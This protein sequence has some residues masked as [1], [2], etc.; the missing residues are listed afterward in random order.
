MVDIITPRGTFSIIINSRLT[1]PAD[2]GE[3]G[4]AVQY[5]ADFTIVIA[6]V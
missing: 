3:E 2:A 4:A 1:P 6:H 5:G